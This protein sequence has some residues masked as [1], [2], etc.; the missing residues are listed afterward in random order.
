MSLGG[1]LVHSTPF[2]R[3]RR[4]PHSPHHLAGAASSGRC[5]DRYLLSS[6]NPRKILIGEKNVKP[7]FHI[8]VSS[9]KRTIQDTQEHRGSNKFVTVMHSCKA[10]SNCKTGWTR[11][12]PM[13]NCEM[14]CLPAETQ[15]SL[16]W[17]L[18]GHEHMVQSGRPC[19]TAPP[20]APP[21]CTQ[22]QVQT[23]RA[24]VLSLP[25]PQQ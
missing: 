1:N 7:T 14:E 22:L 13:Q 5:R 24:P 23:N 15:Q 10:T 11:A 20:L 17:R 19:L 21:K 9:H 12:I 3:L 6:K 18:W 8:S 2:N 16:L 4:E 25:V